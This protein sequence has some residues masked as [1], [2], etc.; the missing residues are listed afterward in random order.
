M[1]ENP[2]DLNS[3]L[4]SPPD[5][6]APAGRCRGGPAPLYPP[7]RGR[8]VRDTRRASLLARETRQTL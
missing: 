8:R 6:G 2:R 1:N 4:S 7:A 3:L 5:T